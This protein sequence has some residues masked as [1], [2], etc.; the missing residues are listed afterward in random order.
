MEPE[1]DMKFGFIVKHRGIGRRVGCGRRS[2]SRE[3]GSMPGDTT[4]QS[5]QQE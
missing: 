2:M 1:V 3:A 5:A 4:A